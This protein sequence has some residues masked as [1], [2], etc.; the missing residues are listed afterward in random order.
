M[1]TRWLRRKGNGAKAAQVEEGLVACREDLEIHWSDAGKHRGLEP[2]TISLDLRYTMPSLLSVCIINQRA[3]TI[4]LRVQ[5]GGLCSR[6]GKT[7]EGQWRWECLDRGLPGGRERM[8]SGHSFFR[9]WVPCK[10]KIKNILLGSFLHSLL[11][12]TTKNKQLGWELAQGQQ[13]RRTGSWCGFYNP[14]V[15]QYQ[16]QWQLSLAGQWP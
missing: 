9:I 3:R 10:D 7:R 15:P 4:R 6:L 8:P 16:L 5:R 2:R 13:C 11:T 12:Y 1:W 14:E